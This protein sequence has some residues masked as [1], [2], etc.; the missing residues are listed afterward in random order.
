MAVEW[1]RSCYQS[2][3][4]FFADDP[5]RKTPGR[6]YFSPPGAPFYAH[7]HILASRNWLDKNWSAVQT[8]GEDLTEPQQW[9]SG[10]LPAVRVSTASVG[11]EAC[12]ADGEFILNGIP[13]EDLV[14]GFRDVCIL[15]TPPRTATWEAAS[16]F[17]SCSIQLASARIIEW[18]YDANTV[19]I[20]DFLVPFLGAGWTVVWHPPTTL[21]PSVTTAVCSEGTLCWVDGT[22]N[23]QQFALQAAY[24]LI[25]PQNV[26]GFGTSGFWFSCSNWINGKL[27]AAGF[28]PSKPVFFAGHSY[29]AVA[30]LV[31]AARMLL[32]DNTR[33]I[34]FLSYGCPHVGNNAMVQL[35]RRGTG[36]Q[37]RNDDDIVTAIPPN[38]EQL[39]PV[40]AVLI[41][42]ALLSWPTWKKAPFGVMQDDNGALT[43]DEEPLLDYPTLLV[44]AIDVLA[45]LPYPTVEGHTITEYFRRISVRCAAPEWPLTD[46][47]YTKI[48]S[49]DLILMND[50]SPML[51]NDN[52]PMLMNS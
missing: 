50:T 7:R 49:T 45:A 20:F 4:H 42:P 37:L 10:G 36:L 26:G 5:G 19:S 22:V 9:N 47:E 21:F 18:M 46:E 29:G 32:A 38:L 15:P 25:P 44:F 41:N 52:T 11:S 13:A 17:N 14:N 6:Y 51:M 12:L 1:L 16:D 34:R 33:T 40:L 35:L 8:L 24:A 3:W 43:P 31:L 48:F 2:S 27:A 23:F 30:A 39:L 28:D